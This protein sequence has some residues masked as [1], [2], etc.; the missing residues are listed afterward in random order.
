MKAF[1]FIFLGGGAGSILRYGVQLALHE[2]ILPHHFPWA[3][4]AV[5][6]LGSF[7]IGL[8]YAL[9]ARLHLTT[10]VRL[11]LT[12]GLCGGFTTFSTFS[13]ESLTLLRQGY[14]TEFT[15]YMTGSLLLGM[16][17]V[18]LGGWCGARMG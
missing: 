7:L 1:L 13:N 14:Y 15:L 4:L 3:T 12:T 6:I 18:L 5:N 9:S 8:C 11:L 10:E 16:A 17:A 2:R